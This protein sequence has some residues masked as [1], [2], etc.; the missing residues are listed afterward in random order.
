MQICPKCKI[1]IR[2]KKRCC[3][4][5]QGQ[6]KVTEGEKSP[7]FPTLKKKKISHI[8]FLKM[9]TFLFVA[10]EIVFSAIN[11]MT[12]RIYSFFGPLML[13]FLAGWITILTTMYLRNNILKVVTWEVIV[14]IV[15]DI[16]IDFKTGFYG[17]SVEWMVPMTL[18]GL[19]ITTIIIA[20]VQKLRLDEY[21]Y[22]IIFDLAMALGQIYFIKK[23]LNKLIWP[24]GISIMCYLILIAAVVIFRFRDLKKASEKMFNM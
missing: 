6:L 22:Y 19:A 16:Y 24:A 9:C 7:S 5:C 8:T 1:E 4:L 21:I 11:I 17:W 20:L 13:G 12:G 10:T 23:G 14:A 2:G 18:I 15:V 3:P